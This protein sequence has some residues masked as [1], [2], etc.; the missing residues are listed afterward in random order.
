MTVLTEIKENWVTV[1]IMIGVVY[2]ILFGVIVGLILLNDLNEP[3]YTKE[4]HSNMFYISITGLTVLTLIIFFI[5]F[6]WK[7]KI[8]FKGEKSE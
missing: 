6:D 2:G 5:L 4:T 3:I 8:K 1:L 7:I